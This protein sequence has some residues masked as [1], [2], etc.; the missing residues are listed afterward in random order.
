MDHG[1][2]AVE[3]PHDVEFVARLLRPFGFERVRKHDRLD[4]MF[5]P[6]VPKEFPPEGDLLGRVPVPL[7]LSNAAMSLAIQSATGITEIVKSLART[8]DRVESQAFIGIGVLFDADD[9]AVGNYQRFL[10]D[11]KCVELGLTWPDTAGTVT[12]GSPRCG[13]FVLPDNTSAGSLET[14]LLECGDAIYPSLSAGS[15]TF[16]ASAES[17]GSLVET[18]LKELQKPRGR[19]KAIVGCVANVLRPGKAIQVSIQDNRWLDGAG[20]ELPRISVVRQFLVDLFGLTLPSVATAVGG[21][22]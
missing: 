16:V 19:D 18:D 22:P 21:N 15:R 10:T 14:L 9:S 8:F 12:E 7:F 6:L 17:G 3:G 4:P 20:L 5:W 11:P 2:L 13:V 1:L